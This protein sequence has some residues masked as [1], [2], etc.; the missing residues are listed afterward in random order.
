MEVLGKRTKK[1][2]AL[3]DEHGHTRDDEALNEP[4]AQE[5]LNGDATVDVRVM[6]AGGGELGD[7]VGRIARH[8]FQF[9]AA[10]AGE[11]EP[12][13]AEDYN[14]LVAVRPIG[15][16]ENSFK[17][18]AT[19]YENVHTSEEFVETVRFSTVAGQEIELTVWPSD[20]AVDAGADE[21]GSEHGRKSKRKRRK[22]YKSKKANRTSK[23]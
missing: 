3:A 15:K 5:L 21:H 10:N 9:G 17:R 2:N 16:R 12:P 22:K 20:E 4:R 23:K 13:T 19:D 1:R 11:V 14:A 8:L 18:F 7:N 6:R